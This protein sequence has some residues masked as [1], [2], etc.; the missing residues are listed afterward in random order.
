M[1]S[2]L[3]LLSNLAFAWDR[4]EGL[5][6]EE[7]YLLKQEY[8]Y[9]INVDV[10]IHF[11]KKSYFTNDDV[12]RT[13]FDSAFYSFHQI[14]YYGRIDKQMLKGV[15]IELYELT[16]SE[17]ND[18][19]RF[20]PDDVLNPLKNSPELVGFFEPSKTDPYT[21]YIAVTHVSDWDYD[22]RTLVH[23]FAHYWYYTFGMIMFYNGTSESFAQKI[24][25]LVTPRGR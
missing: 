12:S 9:G 2:L 1:M 23:E 18:P 7:P 8:F 16:E 25:D 21:T 19:K 22:Y 10:N 20:P 6:F 4:V 14:E 3:F 17:I 5:K 15:K 13:L 24:N 11:H